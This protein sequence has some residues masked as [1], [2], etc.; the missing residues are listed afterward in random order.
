M[1]VSQFGFNKETMMITEESENAFPK[2]ALHKIAEKSEYYGPL[3]SAIGIRREKS[4]EAIKICKA[5]PVPTPPKFFS[6][7]LSAQESLQNK[8][9][10]SDDRMMVKGYGR[11]GL[12]L[13][14]E[15]KKGVL[16]TG[17]RSSERLL[18]FR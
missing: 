10:I 12:L 6:L 5:P 17:K 2:A 15:L 11:E 16:K 1:I 4:L 14:I 18:N 9:N 3:K 13:A 7:P 8:F